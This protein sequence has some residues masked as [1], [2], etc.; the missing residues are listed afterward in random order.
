M[1]AARQSEASAMTAPS[2][3]PFDLKSTAWTLAALRLHAADVPALGAALDARFGDTP[4]LFDDEALVID[5]SPLAAADT[6]PDFD[7]LLPLLRRFRLRPVAVQG[8]GPAQAAAAR[9]AGLAEAMDPEPLAVPP[10]AAPPVAAA[11]APAVPEPPPGTLV[12]DRPLRSG[13]RVYARG[14]DLVVLSVVSFGA[15]VIADGHIH[16]YAPLRG[17]AMAGARGDASARIFST[18]MEPQLVS[19]AG[20]YRTTETPLPATVAGR[21]AMVRLEGESLLVEPLGA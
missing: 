9:A 1:N 2:K 15:E 13:Q 20:I 14:G 18:C 17:R 6:V 4:D 16:V 8:A 21:A 19:I 5:L 7:A 12:V 10:A 3:P 11:A